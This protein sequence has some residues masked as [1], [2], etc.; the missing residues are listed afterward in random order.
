MSKRQLCVRGCL[1]LVEKCSAMPRHDSLWPCAVLEEEVQ[2]LEKQAAAARRAY[3]ESAAQLEQR[4][5]RLRECDKEISAVAREGEELSKQLT[6]TNVER[7]KLEH[8]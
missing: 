6:D 7:Q 4:R 8:K 5:A 2:E 3:E 1:L